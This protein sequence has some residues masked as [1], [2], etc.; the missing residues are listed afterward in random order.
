MSCSIPVCLLFLLLT[1]TFQKGNW[2]RKVKHSHDII[3]VTFQVCDMTNMNE[4]VH[5]W[6]ELTALS[7]VT[8]TLGHMLSKTFVKTSKTIIFRRVSYLK[9]QQWDALQPPERNIASADRTCWLKVLQEKEHKYSSNRGQSICCAIKLSF[10][11]LF[12]KI[13]RSFFKMP[14]RCFFC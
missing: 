6:G 4:L 7:K 11:P 8:D 1:L 14:E 5:Y 10:C 2:E 9:Q 3:Q 12:E 13:L